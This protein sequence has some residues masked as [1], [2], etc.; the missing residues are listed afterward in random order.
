VQIYKNIFHLRDIGDQ[1][2]PFFLEGVQQIFTCL[3]VKNVKKSKIDQAYCKDMHQCGT[4]DFPSCRISC[5]KAADSVKIPFGLVN[6]LIFV[7]H[8]R[9]IQ[10]SV[11]FLSSQ[12]TASQYIYYKPKSFFSLEHSL[13]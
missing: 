1:F 11:K 6:F 3:F 8:R 7:S 4:H 12:S 10:V 13:P 9:L 2:F 5:G